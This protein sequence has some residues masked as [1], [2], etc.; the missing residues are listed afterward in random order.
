MSIQPNE[1]EQNLIDSINQ[2]QK[3]IDIQYTNN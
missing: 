1:N 3:N 2:I